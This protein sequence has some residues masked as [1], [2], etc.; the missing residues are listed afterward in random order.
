MKPY[1]VDKQ[2]LSAELLLKE[3]DYCFKMT[4]Q[5]YK[6]ED[7]KKRSSKKRHMSELKCYD[8]D[9][10]YKFIKM[11][12]S[13][14][15]LSDDKSILKYRRLIYPAISLDNNFYSTLSAQSIKQC[16][17]ILN[18][19]LG[20]LD[21][22][23]I[24]IAQSFLLHQFP[25]VGGFQSSCIFNSNNFGGFVSGKFVQI[26]NV[27]NSHWVLISNVTSDNGS[28]SVQYYDSLF[29]GFNKNT[30]PLLVHRVARSILINEGI[31]FINLEVMRCQNQDNGNDC[32]LHAIANATALC[33]G[34]DPSVI[35]WERNSM[36]SHF[37]KCVENRKLEMFPS[38]LSNGTKTCSISFQCDDLCPC[39][40]K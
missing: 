26:F 35:L 31:E 38:I 2:V 18:N 10:N 15:S 19:P 11:E 22:T 27:R 21:D 33:H 16:I 5:S 3:H 17:Y 24:D 23:L 9:E 4:N 7:L 40:L 32:G 13:T 12:I 37:L 8:K 25:K 14:S 1:I 34:I 29:T 6:K 30:V 20:W 36:R 39:A 28:N